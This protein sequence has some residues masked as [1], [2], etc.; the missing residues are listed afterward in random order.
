MTILSKKLV[1]NK[2]ALGHF[3]RNTEQ[4]AKAE[5]ELSYFAKGIP[6]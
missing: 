5:I 2:L 4:G 1:Y 6:A 3:V